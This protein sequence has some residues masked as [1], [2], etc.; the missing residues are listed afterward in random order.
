MLVCLPDS[1]RVT[2]MLACPPDSLRVS[3]SRETLFL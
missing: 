2:L 1:L 3:V